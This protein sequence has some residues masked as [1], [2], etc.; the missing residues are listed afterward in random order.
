MK[1]ACQLVQHVFHHTAVAV[2]AD[3]QHA[4]VF[5]AGISD[6]HVG[7]L[8]GVQAATHTDVTDVRTCVDD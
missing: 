6:I 3:A 8:F 1:Q 4:D 2:I 7:A 5:L